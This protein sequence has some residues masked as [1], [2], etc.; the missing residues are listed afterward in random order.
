MFLQYMV[1]L[2]VFVTGYTAT[3]LY[4][5]G[6]ELDQFILNRSNTFWIGLVPVIVG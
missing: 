1:V 4:Y 2:T 3:L 6:F 5:V